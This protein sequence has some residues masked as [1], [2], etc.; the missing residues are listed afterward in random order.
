MGRRA[1]S[2]RPTG[3]MVRE[4]RAGQETLPYKAI[5]VLGD[6]ATAAAMKPHLSLRNQMGLLKTP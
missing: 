4:G 6:M 1:G 5:S 2:S 3:I